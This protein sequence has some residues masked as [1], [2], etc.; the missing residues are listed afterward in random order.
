ML[1]SPDPP[2]P[3]GARAVLIS[4]GGQNLP[5]SGTILLPSLVPIWHRN[6]PKC[7]D[8][9]P[10]CNQLAIPGLRK[11]TPQS[12]PLVAHRRDFALLEGDGAVTFGRVLRPVEKAQRV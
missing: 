9:A 1:R 11:I 4:P 5:Q 6:R 3:T 7:A 8:S 10:I 12:V 2:E